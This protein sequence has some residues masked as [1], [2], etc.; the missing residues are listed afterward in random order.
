MRS[1]PLLT[2]TITVAALLLASLR[3]ASASGNGDAARAFTEEIEPLLDQYCYDCHG[4][5]SDKGGVILDEFADA[6]ALLDHALWLRALKN[7]RGG[8]MPPNDEAQPSAEEQAKILDWIKNKVFALDAVNPDPGRVTLR[9]LNRVEY[10]NTIDALLGIDFDTSQEFP[11]DD[12]G[13]GF[14]NIADVL[15][16]S[17]MLLEKYLDAAQKIIAEAVPTQPRVVAEFEIAGSKFLADGESAEGREGATRDISYYKPIVASA[18]REIELDGAYQ[19]VV[20]FTA[21][22]TYVNNQFD[23]NECQLIFKIDGETALRRT[24]VRESQRSYKFVYDRDWKAGE[25]ELSFEVIPLT[26]DA[27]QIRDLRFQ[28]NSVVV[29]GP[30]REEHWVEPKRYTSFFP[31]PVPAS[32]ERRR[33]YARQLLSDFAFRAYRRPVESRTVERLLALAEYAASLEGSTFE[34]GVAQAMVAVLASPRF[35]FREEMALPLAEGEKH[36]LIDEFALA[37]RLSYFLWSTMPDDE[38]FALA[39]KGEL[40]EQ[41]GPQIERM[42]ADKRSRNFVNNFTGQ[43]LQARDIE[44]VAISSFAVWLRENPNPELEKAQKEFRRIRKIR[45]EERTEQ[46][47]ADLAA[48]RSIF[49]A[50]F[51]IPKPDLDGELREAMRLESEMVFEHVLQE[52]RS[53]VELIESDYTFLNERLAEHY[54]IEGVEGEEMRKVTLPEDSSRGGVLTQ[55][56]VLAV[57]SNP[58]RTSPVKRGVFI[59]DNILGMPPPPPPPNIPALEDAAS[60]EELAE[61]SLRETLELH[62]KKRACRSCHSRM[63]PLGLALENFNA[64]GAWRDNE[65]NLPIDPRGDLF[66]GESFANVQTLKSVIANERRKDFYHCFSEKIL[67]YALGRGL[68]Y[69]DTYTLDQLVEGLEESDGNLSDLIVN[70]VNS[71]PFQRRR[72]QESDTI[73]EPQETSPELA[74]ANK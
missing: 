9:R 12:T 14:D 16:V 41:L 38:L 68:E 71:A 4:Y 54:N 19:V 11:A 30:M 13:H 59:L 74:Q 31:R 23:Y 56:T 29:R 51:R 69:Y 40:R 52:D 10:R 1:S 34:A 61:M 6:N 8:V 50:S 43:W 65:M 25:H 17:P 55:G 3:A 63:D 26:P 58:T 39:Q 62:A 64:M 32:L 18:T 22:E 70:V 28:L 47:S 57:T 20:D 73:G 37:S 60:E 66:T 7:L 24:F 45:A 49:F 44:G 21:I 2:V 27:E 35:L 36:P 33:E 42:L 15:T 72:H 5:G 46:E 48:A 53:L 67:T